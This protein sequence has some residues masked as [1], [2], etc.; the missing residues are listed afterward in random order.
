MSR[1]IDMKVT[2]LKTPNKFEALFG[3]VSGGLGPFGIPTACRKK[4]FLDEVKLMVTMRDSI[5]RLLKECDHVRDEKRL[6]II[7][8]GWLQFGLELNF[9]AMDWM[10][11][12]VYRFG[13]IDRCRI[14]ADID[15]CDIL[16][17][18]YCILNLLQRKLLDTERAVRNLFSNNTKRKRRQIASESRAELNVNPSFTINSLAIT[19][20]PQQA[21]FSSNISV[22]PGAPLLSPSGDNATQTIIYNITKEVYGGTWSLMFIENYLIRSTGL[23]R[24]LSAGLNITFPASTTPSSS[25]SLL[26]TGTAPITFVST[27]SS[28]SYQTITTTN[29]AG[30]TYLITGYVPPI[31]Q[32]VTITPFPTARSSYT[33]T[34]ISNGNMNNSEYEWWSNK[35]YLM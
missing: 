9:Y 28:A 21:S 13:L 3:E 17:D 5:N 8:F 15:D 23:S 1:K 34:P 25:S 2:L 35:I 30:Q 33:Y 4:R 26:I 19:L 10:G 14:P 29:A 18:A 11:S 22:T 12:G 6:E 20:V 27:I 16:E 31:I 24:V 32:T 7:V